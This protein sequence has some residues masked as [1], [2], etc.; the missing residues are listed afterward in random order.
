MRTVAG[1]ESWLFFVALDADVLFV[2]HDVSSLRLFSDENTTIL[3]EPVSNATP[4][5]YAHVKEG[6]H[7]FYALST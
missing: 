2:K 5:Y 7:V 3:W 4:V 1:E 6:K